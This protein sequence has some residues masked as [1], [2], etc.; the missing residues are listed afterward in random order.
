MT[1]AREPV[2]RE[3]AQAQQPKRRES[4]QSRAQRRCRR[5]LY[6]YIVVVLVT[7]PPLLPTLCV[8]NWNGFAFTH[9]TYKH[10][11]RARAYGIATRQSCTELRCFCCVGCTK[12]K[13]R[14]RCTRALPYMHS[15]YIQHSGR[16]VRRFSN[17]K[18]SRSRDLHKTYLSSFWIEFIP[19][20]YCCDMT[21][22][23]HWAIYWNVSQKCSI[24]IKLRLNCKNRFA[25]KK[26][27]YKQRHYKVH[28]HLNVLY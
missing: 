15:A 19:F 21:K 18:I 14:G 25:K 17:T 16:K 23:T 2:S 13:I 28:Q 20:F 12:R 26:L 27:K 7:L 4:A 9:R 11:Y 3:Q 8:Y 5:V 24:F 6:N 1:N 10:K 22:K